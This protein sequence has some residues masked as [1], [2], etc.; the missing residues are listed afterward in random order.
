MDEIIQLDK[1]ILLYSISANS[2]NFIELIEDENL[3]RMGRSYF[4]EDEFLDKWKKNGRKMMK[5]LPIE[6]IR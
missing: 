5:K 1:E 2:N 4:N 6:R 3:I